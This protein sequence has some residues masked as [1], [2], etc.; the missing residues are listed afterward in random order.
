MRLKQ[1][2]SGLGHRARHPAA[3]LRTLSDP[4][5]PLTL[6]ANRFGTDKGS[7]AHSGH[8]YAE[9][10]H[11]ILAP[12][13]D[14]PVRL[15]EIGLLHRADKAWLQDPVQHAGAASGERAPSLAMW[16][17]YFPRGEIFGFDFNDFSGV[18]VERCTI[19]RGDMG[20][21]DDLARL[22]RETGGGFDVV[23]EDASHASHHQQ[24]ALAALFPALKPGG[25]YFIEDLHFQRPELEAPDAVKTVDLLRRAGQ[26]LGFASPHIEAGEADYLAAHVDRIELYDSLERGT[27]RSRRRD[28]L[29]AL[30][31]RE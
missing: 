14:K 29:A 23:V 2:L 16:S 12:L 25:V 21:R 31:K 13:R 24:I 10:Y 28:A 6:F 15:L 17:A 7:S 22:V 20:N 4:F 18:R 27:S 26:G 5:D 11:E 9:V 3:L 8:G 19:F 30:F 1:R